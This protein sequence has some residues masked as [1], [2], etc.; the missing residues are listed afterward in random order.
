MNTPLK[1]DA[2]NVVTFHYTLKGEDGAEIETSVGKD[3]VIY[4]HGHANIVPGL[5]QEMTGRQG[6]DTFSATVAAN[7]SPL[8]R[9]VISCSRPGT[10]FAWPCM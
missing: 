2:D 6:G 7:L 4:M 9:P 10:M 8:C 5:E 3:P 1:I